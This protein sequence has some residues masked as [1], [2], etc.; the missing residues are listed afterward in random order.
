MDEFKGNRG[1]E[2]YECI[3]SDGVK[4]V[5][6]DIVGGG[7]EVCVRKYFGKLRK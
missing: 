6:V 1:G 3:I 5:V 2:K 4:K 7:R